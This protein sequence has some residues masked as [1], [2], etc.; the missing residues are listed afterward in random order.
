MTQ[1]TTYP[2]PE[3]AIRYGTQMAAYVHHPRNFPG[4][5]RSRRVRWASWFPMIG[6]LVVPPGV[7]TRAAPD[8]ETELH[9]QAIIVARSHGFA[10]SASTPDL[11]ELYFR[12]FCGHHVDLLS[13]VTVVDKA[14]GALRYERR[15]FPWPSDGWPEPLR[16]ITGSIV[17]V[18]RQ[19][20]EWSTS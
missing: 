10:Y 1:D 16:T 9:A 15:G 4:H 2:V 11:T 19:V 6:G 14:S 8:P 17:D 18:V 3:E 20:L 5:R 12:R 7:I 13:L